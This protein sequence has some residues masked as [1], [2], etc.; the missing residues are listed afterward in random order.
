MTRLTGPDCTVMYNS[1]T[2]FAKKG[3]TSLF[4][5]QKMGTPR[6]R[7][8]EATVPPGRPKRNKTWRKPLVFDGRYTVLA[9]SL[10]LKY[11]KGI[12]YS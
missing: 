12:Q 5:R 8:N 2:G 6:K 1:V 7:K 11:K 9:L 10:G 4:L 3:Y